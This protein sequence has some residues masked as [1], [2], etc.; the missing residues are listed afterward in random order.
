MAVSSEAA[1]RGWWASDIF[2]T[3]ARRS[4]TAVERQRR[5]PAIDACA[6]GAGGGEWVL[7]FRVGADIQVAA[8]NKNNPG[9][10]G[11]FV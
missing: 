4:D 1:G 3:H 11:V 5:T 9:H 8:M 7:P 6:I 2:V 10:A